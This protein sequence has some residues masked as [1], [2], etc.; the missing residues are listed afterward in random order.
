MAQLGNRNL[1]PYVYC[2]IQ[3]TRFFAGNTRHRSRKLWI[4]RSETTQFVCSRYRV[5]LRTV[6]S[7]QRAVGDSSFPGSIE[8]Y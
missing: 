2:L 6:Y 5:E 3:A 8:A 7:V 4:L 1:L